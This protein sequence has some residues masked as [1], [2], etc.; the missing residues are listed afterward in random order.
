MDFIVKSILDY[1][2]NLSF[3]MTLLWLLG[4]R[5]FVI[6]EYL[7]SVR[8]HRRSHCL[9]RLSRIKASSLC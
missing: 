8:V 9:N 2:T 3:V 7:H 4:L 6:S 1:G 5:A